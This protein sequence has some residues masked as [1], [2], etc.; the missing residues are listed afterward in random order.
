MTDAAA[1]RYQAA[2]PSFT[3]ACHGKGI[4]ICYIPRISSKNSPDT[5]TMR[6]S[7]IRQFL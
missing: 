7:R 4:L 5:A 1:W 2:V 3:I 6:G